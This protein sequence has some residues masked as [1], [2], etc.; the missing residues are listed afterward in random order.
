MTTASASRNAFGRPAAVAT[1]DAIPSNQSIMQNSP[2]V[3]GLLGCDSAKA[4][5][6]GRRRPRKA[7]ETETE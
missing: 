2:P 6:M 5:M 7:P 4:M 1:F 3:A